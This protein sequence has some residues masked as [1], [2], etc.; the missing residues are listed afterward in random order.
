MEGNKEGKVEGQDQKIIDAQLK[1]RS[2][3]RG[4]DNRKDKKEER[5]SGI[6]AARRERNQPKEA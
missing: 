4:Q 1:L 3:L 6:E 5:K 2:Q